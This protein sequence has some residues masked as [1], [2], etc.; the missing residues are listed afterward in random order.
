MPFF[1]CQKNAPDQLRKTP[2]KHTYIKGIV[3]IAYLSG[4][5]FTNSKQEM[6]CKVFYLFKNQISTYIAGFKKSS[7]VTEKLLGF[8]NKRAFFLESGGIFCKL[9]PFILL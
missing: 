2:I 5:I 6:F 1:C 7:F 9:L 8:P 4:F 3:I